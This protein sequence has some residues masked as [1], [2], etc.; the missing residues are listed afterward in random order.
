MV[1]R[2]MLSNARKLKQL[3]CGRFDFKGTTDL[4]EELRAFARFLDVDAPT[5]DRVTEAEVVYVHVTG[6]NREPTPLDAEC[7]RA[8]G[9]E[10]KG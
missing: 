9:F 10:P 6:E 2:Q 4:H 1:T 7:V 8:A 5:G 3:S